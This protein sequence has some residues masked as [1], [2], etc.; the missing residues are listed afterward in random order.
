MTKKVASFSEEKIGV[1]PSVAAPADTNP[2]DATDQSYS[3]IKP[4]HYVQCFKNSHKSGLSPSLERT[5]RANYFSTYVIT[6]PLVVLPL[7]ITHLFCWGPQ[8]LGAYWLLL[9]QRLTN[10]FTYL[11]G[12]VY[13]FL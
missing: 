1:T 2:S 11:H 3:S 5:S 9:L 7:M 10:I 6:H 13:L 12:V 8:Q 4:L